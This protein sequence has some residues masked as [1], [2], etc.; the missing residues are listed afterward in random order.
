[1][2]RRIV[3][4]ILPILLAVA[5]V[6]ATTGGIAFASCHVSCD[7]AAM[8]D[9]DFGKTA[10]CKDMGAVCAVSVA[11]T[12]LV[13][14]AA[15]GSSPAASSAMLLVRHL[16]MALPSGLAVAPRPTPPIFLA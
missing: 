12:A 14:M 2:S 3:Q 13:G 5:F 10:P 1:M 11:C 6:N 7:M 9:G 16:P 15:H 8:G 4:Y